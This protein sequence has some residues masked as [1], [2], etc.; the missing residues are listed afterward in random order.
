[1]K[2]KLNFKGMLDSLSTPVAL[3]IF[4]SRLLSINKKYS[5]IA[6]YT[7]ND[8]SN[9]HVYSEEIQPTNSWTYNIGI[10]EFTD[11]EIPETFSY[12]IKNKFC[13]IF[14]VETSNQFFNDQGYHTT[15]ISFKNSAGTKPGMF[16]TNSRTVKS[17][18]VASS[19]YNSSM[20]VKQLHV[21]RIFDHITPPGHSIK[22]IFMDNQSVCRF[23]VTEVIAFSSFGN[24]EI[25]KVKINHS[26]D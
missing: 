13:E 16:Y 22:S 19:S 25:N 9:L 6:G 8:I 15:P 1:M 17:N 12:T 2:I 23:T 18:F 14:R 7:I 10:L 26:N 24:E 21:N 5:S 20:R 4:D 11:N 3:T